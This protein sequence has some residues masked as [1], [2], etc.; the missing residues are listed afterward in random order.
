VTKPEINGL[1]VDVAA[2]EAS[3]G[4][5]RVCF[6]PHSGVANGL[7]K[8][9]NLAPVACT[10]PPPSSTSAAA[11]ETVLVALVDTGA[12]RSA[13]SPAAAARVGLAPRLLDP[14][15]TRTVEGVGSAV[16]FG[17]TFFAPGAWHAK[18]P[19][20]GVAGFLPNELH[21]IERQKTNKMKSNE[22]EP[23]TYCIRYFK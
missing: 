15:F 21:R 22:I 3:K 16:G 11:S 20:P 7:L 23:I 9:E 8:P 4:R 17:L 14:G 10:V 2:F 19:A 12:E 6:P 13:M 18:R 1:L 5:Y